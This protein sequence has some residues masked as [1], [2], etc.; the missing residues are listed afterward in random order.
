MD[1]MLDLRAVG[2]DIVTLGQYLQPT[3]R[4]LDVTEFVPPEKF[5]HWRK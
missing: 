5:D 4:H 2:V 1:T 3:E